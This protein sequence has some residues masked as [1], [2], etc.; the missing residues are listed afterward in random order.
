MPAPVS[1]EDSPSLPS[2]SVTC[3]P[4]ALGLI[5]PHCLGEG[6][7]CWLLLCDHFSVR[8]PEFTQTSSQS[9]PLHLPKAGV[10]R[11]FLQRVRMKV[12]VCMNSQRIT[13]DIYT[14]GERNQFQ[15]VSALLNPNGSQTL[16]GVAV[17]R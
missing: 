6:W 13:K 8:I 9:L 5:P 1:S 10:C 7:W 17:C 2:R 3:S 16:T 12:S 4:M 14:G 15:M 11:P